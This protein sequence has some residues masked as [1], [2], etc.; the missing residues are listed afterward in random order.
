MAADTLKVVHI[1][2]SS[3]FALESCPNIWNCYR[4]TKESMMLMIIQQKKVISCLIY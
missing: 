3:L 2:A 1:A 4:E